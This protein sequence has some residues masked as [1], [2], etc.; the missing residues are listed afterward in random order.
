M[1]K[2]SHP[3]GPKKNKSGW[4]NPGMGVLLLVILKAENLN[5]YDV[6]CTIPVDVIFSLNLNQT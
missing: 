5:R 3:D 6:C 2:P 4:K 1:I